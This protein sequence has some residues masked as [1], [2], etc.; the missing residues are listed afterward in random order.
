MRREAWATTGEHWVIKTL[1]S[2]GARVS[3]CV[4]LKAEEV[5]LDEQMLLITK[6]K[7]GKSRYVPILPALAQELSMHLGQRTVGL[8]FETNRATRSSPRRIQPI[9]K[10]TAAQAQITKRVSPPRLR[11]AVGTLL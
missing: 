1:F 7:G 5:F 2:T 4:H 11:H 3:A 9:M 8:L 10:A 6:A